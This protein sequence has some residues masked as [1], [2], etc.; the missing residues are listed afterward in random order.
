MIIYC[1][2]TV[3]VVVEHVNSAQVYEMAPE[4]AELVV[5]IM[6]RMDR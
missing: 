3:F 4:M 2:F 1:F 6:N 5:D